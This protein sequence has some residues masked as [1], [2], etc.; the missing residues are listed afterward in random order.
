MINKTQQSV[1]IQ[2]RPR[3]LVVAVCDGVFFIPMSTAAKNNVALNLNWFPDLDNFYH[4]IKDTE[5]LILRPKT[6]W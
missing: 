1:V 3:I 5:K 6:A 4:L 2:E